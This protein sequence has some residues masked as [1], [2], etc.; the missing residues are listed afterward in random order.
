MQMH[1]ICYPTHNKYTSHVQTQKCARPSSWDVLAQAT[2]KGGSNAGFYL[3]CGAAGALLQHLMEWA[4][5]LAHSLT[6]ELVG[7]TAHMA[8]D[9]GACLCS[10]MFK[11]KCELH[12]CTQSTH[13]HTYTHTGSIEALE[14]LPQPSPGKSSAGAGLCTNQRAPTTNRQPAAA[15][16]SVGGGGPTNF[17]CVCVQ[18]KGEGTDQIAFCT[19]AHMQPLITHTYL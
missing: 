13:T 2:A 18:I 6:V 15:V 17:R 4:S 8:W 14:I 11:Q 9:A 16:G 3:A 5:V 19:G 10:F 12:K 1:T 7:T